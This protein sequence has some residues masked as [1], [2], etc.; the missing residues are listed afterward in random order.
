[1]DHNHLVQRC[2]DRLTRQAVVDHNHLVQRCCDRLAR[3]AVSQ[4]LGTEML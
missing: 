4:S 1:M 2:C 3:Q